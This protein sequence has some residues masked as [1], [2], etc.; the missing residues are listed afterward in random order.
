M[1]NTQF[2]QSVIFERFAIRRF[3]ASTV[4]SNGIN[5]QRTHGSRDPL[6]GPHAREPNPPRIP[7]NFRYT[8]PA[9][10]TGICNQ[11][12]NLDTHTDNA[13]WRGLSKFPIMPV[14]LC[15]WLRMGWGVSECLRNICPQRMI[16]SEG[17]TTATRILYPINVPP[18]APALGQYVR[19]RTQTV[20]YSIICAYGGGSDS[21]E[22]ANTRTHTHIWTQAYAEFLLWSF[23]GKQ[24]LY[25]RHGNNMG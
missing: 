20:R 11:K 16:R 9:C 1:T 14:C 12:D 22:Q 8:S 4:T 10:R 6:D 25:C 2:T 7:G 17:R 18:L 23:F 3:R 5:S 15:V 13:R 24:D 19:V 21:R